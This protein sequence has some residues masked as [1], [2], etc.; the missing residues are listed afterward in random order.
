MA[1]NWRVQFTFDNVTRAKTRLMHSRHFM[2][3]SVF[4]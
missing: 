3:A 2:P 1:A 4:A